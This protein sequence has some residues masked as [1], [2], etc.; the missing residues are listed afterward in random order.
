MSDEAHT[1]DIDHIVLN[2]V[3]PL[4][5]GR[6][7]ALIE[8]EVLRALGAARLIAS[9]GIANSDARVAGEVAQTDVRSIHGG[10]YDV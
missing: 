9:T 8:A 10:A 1:I 7:N 2:S 6:L 5:P 3:D 4:H